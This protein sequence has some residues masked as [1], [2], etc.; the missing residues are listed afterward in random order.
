MGTYICHSSLN[1]L[2]A[3]SNSTPCVKA[4]NL[5]HVCHVWEVH[6]IAYLTTTYVDNDKYR[7]CAPLRLC[8]SMR[9]TGIWEVGKVAFGSFL[10]RWLPYST[11][12]WSWQYYM[13]K[14]RRVNYINEESC[15]ESFCKALT[16]SWICLS[17]KAATSAPCKGPSH[18]NTIDRWAHPAS[19]TSHPPLAII[20]WFV[21]NSALCTSPEI[22]M[23]KNIRSGLAA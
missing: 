8:V 21:T 22:C 10:K 12:S 9:H 15:F 7:M 18:T 3:E 23:A 11:L 5:R 13:A 2:K 14:R 19:S 17:S 1:N 6:I 20:T 4:K 16:V